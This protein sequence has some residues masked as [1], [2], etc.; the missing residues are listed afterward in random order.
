MSSLCFSDFKITRGPN[1]GEIFYIGPTFE[2]IGLYY[3]TDYG[4]MAICK[5]S[6]TDFG[7]ICADLKLGNIY[8][9]D[10]VGSIYLS[11]NYGEYGSWELRN[12]GIKQQ[13]NSGRVEG[14]VFSSF[15]KV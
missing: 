2:G 15:S 11:E 14:E 8:Y 1:A 9:R 12:S 3:S 5:D 13:V 10:F 7:N 4:N 6:I